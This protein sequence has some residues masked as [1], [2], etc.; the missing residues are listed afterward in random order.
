M[1]YTINL[2]LI[3]IKY[4]LKSLWVYK[5]DF[6]IGSI[7]FIISNGALFFSLLIIYTFVD[8]IGGWNFN[9]I[10]LLY[11]FVTLSKSLW[12]TFMMN[13][14]EIGT[15]I[16]DGTLDIILLRPINPLFQIVSEKLDPDTIGE[17]LFGIVLVS[18]A[19]FSLEIF[20]FLKIGLL[21]L[22][23]VT[24]VLVFAAIHLFIN[25]ISFWTID[26][27]GLNNVI[28]Q[29]DDLATYPLTI[30]PKWLKT[31]ITIIPFAFV[32]YYP[33]GFFLGKDEINLAFGIFI[34][35]SGP[36]FFFLA[37]RF[38]LLGLSRYSSTGS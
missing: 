21:L 22:L 17:V 28:W 3:Y 24:S 11:G 18:Y 31:I 4:A 6:L 10:M 15:K 25:S 32:G 23:L 38:W 16:K 34:V 35:L 27:E 30:F 37:Y 36:I 8:E 7:G 29:L 9:E 26:I 1:K 12:D 13:T 20:S 14:M 2:Y 19:I 5:A 33:L